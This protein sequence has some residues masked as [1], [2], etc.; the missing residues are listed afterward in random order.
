MEEFIKAN[1]DG[2]ELKQLNE[3]R[4]F[5][6][7]DTLSDIATANGSEIT[8]NAWEGQKE[9]RGGSQYQWP[10]TQRAL[11]AEHW[12][13]WRRTLTQMFLA[14]GPPRK[15]QEKLHTW[16]KGLPTK[17][18]W[19]FSPEEDR[20]Y[21]KEGLMWRVY[22]RHLV[23]TSPRQGRSKYSKTEQHVQQ[24]PK[25]MLLASVLKQGSLF[26]LQ[27]SGDATVNLPDPILILELVS[28]DQVRRQREKLDQWAITEITMTDEGKG[29]AQAIKNGTAIAVSDGSYKD[30]KGTAAFILE[31]SDNFNEKDRMV[32][33]N[34]IPGETEDQS[35][36]RSKIGGVSGIVETVGILCSLHTIQAGAIEVG[37]DGEQAMKTIFGNWPLHPKQPDY[38]LLKDL[39]EKSRNPP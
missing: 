6:N 32:G 27:S 18:K 23:R 33:V 24:P 37:L 16:H 28:F 8:I 35:S 12:K 26:I 30:G 17:W 15:L 22:R 10:R 14:T 13:L 7:V 39:R 38:D 21:A 4:M 25:T 20:L 19:Y 2:N 29:I 9:D 31:I 34:S 3:C 11:S 1:V 5:L 36:Y